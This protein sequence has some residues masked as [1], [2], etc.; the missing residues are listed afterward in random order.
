MRIVVV[1]T[2]GT[3]GFDFA[4]S[5]LISVFYVIVLAPGAVALAFKRAWWSWLL[6]AGG[7][8]L[9]IEEAITIGIQETLGSN[10]MT[11]LRWVLLLFT[12]LAMAF[13]Y[14]LQVLYT[15][16]MSFSLSNRYA[17]EAPDS[18]PVPGET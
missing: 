4:G 14:G 1:L 8:V 18:S 9:L 10:N 16:R 12:L 5:V 15:I 7:A 6:L 3:P 2:N 17:A 13:T 11:T